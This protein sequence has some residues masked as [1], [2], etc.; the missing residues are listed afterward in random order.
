MILENSPW[1]WKWSDVEMDH[2]VDTEIEKRNDELV[3]LFKENKEEFDKKFRGIVLGVWQKKGAYGR[4]T[5]EKMD[6][7]IKNHRGFFL[8]RNDLEG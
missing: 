8:I 4:E 2:F 6:F 7:I 1:K 3:K 5:R